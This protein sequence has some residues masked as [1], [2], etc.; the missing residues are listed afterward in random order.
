MKTVLKTQCQ[1]VALKALFW[2]YSELVFR[3]RKVAIRNCMFVGEVFWCFKGR[4]FFEILVGT[5]DARDNFFTVHGKIYCSRKSIRAKLKV[6]GTLKKSS[7]CI[8]FLQAKGKK[9][10]SVSSKVTWASNH[11]GTGELPL[12]TVKM[13]RFCPNMIE[14]TLFYQPPKA[15]K[16][17][18]YLFL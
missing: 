11:T 4:C 2:T 10:S 7:T 14:E 5:F 3:L 1:V 8:H 13:E 16:I 15:E 6:G 18:T 12:G 9:Y 17:G